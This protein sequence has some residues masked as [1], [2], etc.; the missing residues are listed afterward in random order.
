M[1]FLVF[2]LLIALA[3]VLVAL[4]RR[5]F[6]DAAEGEAEASTAV[7]PAPVSYAQEVARQLAQATPAEF[8]TLR[9]LR[10]QGMQTFLADRDSPL[11]RRLVRGG[12][13]S[14]AGSSAYP[15]DAFPYRVPDEVWAQLEP[16]SGPSAGAS[17]R[18][19]DAKGSAGPSAP[20]RRADGEP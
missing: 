15:A 3:V 5:L 16:A 10:R 12:L 8:A 7:A 11:L 19:S 6:Q 17:Q 14:G 2:G 20:F 18:T 1:M 4:A 13:L 9:H